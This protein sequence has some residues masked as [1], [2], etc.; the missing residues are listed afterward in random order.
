MSVLTLLRIFTERGLSGFN[1]TL[2]KIVAY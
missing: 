2:V 1:P